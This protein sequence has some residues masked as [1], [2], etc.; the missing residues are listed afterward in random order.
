MLQKALGTKLYCYIKRERL[1]LNIYFNSASQIWGYL[2]TA[3][4]LK[5]LGM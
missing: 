4:L 1:F 5:Y 2:L 3:A